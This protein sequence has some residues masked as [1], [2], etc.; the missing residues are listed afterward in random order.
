MDTA[1]RDTHTHTHKTGKA[2]TEHIFKREAICAPQAVIK[3]LAV[4]PSTCFLYSV[5]NSLITLCTHPVRG[6][7]G[8]RRTKEGDGKTNH[9]IEG[10][11]FWKNGTVL[12]VLRSTF[13]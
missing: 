2:D 5:S 3:L 10:G 9:R 12:A 4:Y 7:T 8:E 6:G 13:N 1:T 11:G